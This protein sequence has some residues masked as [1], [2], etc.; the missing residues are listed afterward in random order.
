MGF[1]I[2]MLFEDLTFLPGFNLLVVLLA[3]L[4]LMDAGSIQ[5]QPLPAP[6][7]WFVA[8]LVAAGALLLVVAFGDASAVA[9]RQGTDAAAEGRWPAAYL[10]LRRAEW[11]NPWHPSGPRALVVAADRV[12]EPEVARAAGER[13]TQ[14]SPGEGPSWTNL[15]LLCM[16]DGDRTCALEAADR[17]VEAATPE[18]RE[19]ANA[20]LVYAW[21]GDP[22][23]ADSTYRLSLLT[24]YWTGL[25]L[26]WPRPVLVGDGQADEQGVDA[27]ELNLLIA[28]RL[29][30]EPIR[31]DD[32]AGTVPRALAYAMLG[33]RA[34]ALAE[35]ERATRVAPETPSAWDI[36]ALLTAHYGGDPAPLVAI[37][38]A[39]RGASL[40]RGPARLPGVIF[41]IATFRAYPADG[42]VNAAE[43]LLPETPWPWVLEPLLA[44]ASAR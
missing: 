13:A 5:W 41:D 23:T 3:A 37:G 15:A 44:P 9:Y 36:A 11:L 29:N 10:A 28:R 19:L 17:A 33:E 39:A 22:T 27:A 40:A 38:D 25:T 8:P 26:D 2:G 43:R 20:A 42:L 4:A 34:A 16:A 24:N 7:R 31:V 12:D 35:A 30:G 32:Y 21:L 1:A 6:R 18:G 14:L